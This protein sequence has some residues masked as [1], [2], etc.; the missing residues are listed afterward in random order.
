[1]AG[2]RVFRERTTAEV[3][4]GEVRFHGVNGVSSFEGA[5]RFELIPGGTRVRLVAEVRLRRGLAWSD[6]LAR[7]LAL[8]VLRLDLQGHAR[9]LRKDAG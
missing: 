2:V 5:Y 4:P 8:A 1:M 3:A 7:P 9:D 6:A